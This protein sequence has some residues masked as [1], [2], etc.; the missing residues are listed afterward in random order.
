MK[1]WSQDEAAMWG[2]WLLYKVRMKVDSSI[3]KDLGFLAECHKVM[4]QRLAKAV[5]YLLPMQDSIPSV[6]AMLPKTA[7]VVE[8]LDTARSKT[9]RHQRL[10]APLAIL[11]LVTTSLP[12]R[13]GW[14]RT[15][16][17]PGQQHESR[18]RH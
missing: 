17:G 11:R 7:Y 16:V 8:K 6:P 5:E 13:H 12:S 18:S 14:S 1:P 3:P 4:F 9:L 2:F 10:L 15:P